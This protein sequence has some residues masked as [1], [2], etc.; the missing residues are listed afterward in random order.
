[1]GVYGIKRPEEVDLEYC[2]SLMAEYTALDCAQMFS[3]LKRYGGYR[4]RDRIDICRQMRMQKYIHRIEVEDRKYFVLNPQ[5]SVTGRLQQQ[6][7]CFWLLLDYLDRVDQHFAAGTPSSV[8]TMEIE[9]RDYS[10]LYAAKGKERACNYS[11]ERGGITRYFVMVED[12]SQIPLIKNEQIHA[13]A[14]LD[15]KNTVHYYLPEG[16]K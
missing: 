2:C 3:L 6:I 9:G 1:M 4:K 13:F 5:I 12:L 14:M 11:M 10:I 8:I 7:R 16:A 15:E